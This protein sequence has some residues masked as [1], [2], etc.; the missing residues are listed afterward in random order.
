M[1]NNGSGGGWRGEGEPAAG[2]PAPGLPSEQ[3]CGEGRAG[4]EE[5]EAGRGRGS[6][7]NPRGRGRGQPGRA[8]A[9]LPAVQVLSSPPAPRK[10]RG[11]A[12]RRRRER[13]ER[14]GG[15][16]LPGSAAILAP[17]REQTRRAERARRLR[18]RSTGTYAF[19]FPIL[20]KCWTSLR[21]RSGGSD[22]GQQRGVPSRPAPHVQPWHT[23]RPHAVPR[24]DGLCAQ[25][26]RR[27]A[28]A[29]CRS[30]A[31]AKPSGAF[32]ARQLTAGASQPSRHSGR[33]H[34]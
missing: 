33:S 23:Q 21:E 6:R 31:S 20:A 11:G 14:R 10:S 24:C 7:H 4:E 28:Q 3:R 1:R 32:R 13:G 15:G 9:G 17:S 22:N 30:R 12:G 8:G 19:S 34:T 2:A 27:A 25:R 26:E 29:G 16:R 5:A 18:S